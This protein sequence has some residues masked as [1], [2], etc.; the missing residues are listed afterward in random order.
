MMRSRNGAII[1]LVFPIVG[2]CVVSGDVRAVPAEKTIAHDMALQQVSDTCD[3]WG[4]RWQFGWR[5]YGW[6]ACWDQAKP[7]PTF[8]DPHESPPE[9]LPPAVEALQMQRNC[10]KKWRDSDGKLHARRTC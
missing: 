7:F 6:Y 4:T 8:V 10:V 5:G 9:A 2:A 1:S 3:W